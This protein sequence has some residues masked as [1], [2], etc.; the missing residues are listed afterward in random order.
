M[1]HSQPDVLI[2]RLDPGVP[3]P[4]YAH[5][6]DAGADLTTAEDVELGPG[7]RALVP[8][9]IAIAL[10]DGYAAFVHPRSGLA[11]KHGV[12]LVNAPGT[13]DAG[14]R[15]EI[16][17]TLLNTDRDRAVSFRRG[18]R[19]AQLVIQ[20]VERAVFHEVTVLP[21]SSRGDGGFGSTGQPQRAIH[22]P[23]GVWTPPRLGGLPGGSYGREGAC[24]VFRRRR[25]E[26]ADRDEFDYDEPE[27][28]AGDPRAE[29]GPW[30]AEEPFPALERVDLGS[31]QVPVG[32]EHE[33]QLVMAEQHGAWVTVRYRESEVQIQAFAAARRGALWDDVRAEIAAEVETAGGR[34]QET[35][36]SFGIELMAQVPA[37][38]GQ[39]ASGMR[40]VRFVGV[41]GPRWFLRGLFTGPAADGGEQ[42]EPLEEVLR[43]VVVVRGEHPVP[44]RE[45]L[46]L[47]LPPEAQQALEEQAAA[48]R[49]ASRAGSA[50]T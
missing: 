4:S 3:L 48:D 29:G 5:P 7:E 42:A 2:K 23:E 20:R 16:K 47:Q 34:S 19:I 9:G 30:D 43:D 32:P 45:I 22:P 17:V 15:G 31:L 12:T 10:P 44:P 1:P 37:E 6:G 39:P 26:D 49:R 50:G 21:G 28:P 13:V 11:A 38:P 14:Y 35:D 36:G 46:E 27:Q 8:T 41:D 18:D 25:S 40:L 33:I 24:G